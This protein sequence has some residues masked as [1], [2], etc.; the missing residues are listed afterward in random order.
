MLSHP[1]QH[2]PVFI[3]F[4]QL[5]TSGLSSFM[6]HACL[7]ALWGHSVAVLNM[8]ASSVDSVSLAPEEGNLSSLKD[9]TI[10]SGPQEFS[11]TGQQ[12]PLSHP[13]SGYSVKLCF[14]LNVANQKRIPS[15]FNL[16]FLW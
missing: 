10:E 8:A 11:R 1:E 6:S 15:F 5:N 2:E 13:F 12:V 9:H 7:T 4:V 14:L 3:S 16:I